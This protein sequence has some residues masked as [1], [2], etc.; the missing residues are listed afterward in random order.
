V[1]Q[2]NGSYEEYVAIIADHSCRMLGH[3]LSMR[4]IVQQAGESRCWTWC[5]TLTSIIDVWRVFTTARDR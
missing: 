2:E 1:E 3:D 5:D 4:V